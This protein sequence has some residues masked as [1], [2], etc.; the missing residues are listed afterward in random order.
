MKTVERILLAVSIGA[1][2]PVVGLLAGWWGTF[3][4]APERLVLF[5]ALGGLLAGV[6]LD[7]LFLKKWVDRAYS[8]GLWIWGLIYLFYSVCVYGFFMGVPV[9]NVALGLPAGFLLGCRLA[10]QG[11][12][13]GQVGW[14]A[15]HAS[16]FTTGVLAIACV[17]SAILAL[18]DP[19]TAAD[20]EGMVNLGFKV[21]RG[22]I[23][24]LIPFGGFSIL[25]AQWWLTNKAVEVTYSRFAP[26]G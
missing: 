1:V 5:A 14:A 7:I 18:S 19:H 24:G 26:R 15:R 25:V 2:L 17:A 13:L 4:L 9:F 11:A 23:A 3:S 12:P 20:L 22:M 6:V 21:T 16:W 10:R 8:I